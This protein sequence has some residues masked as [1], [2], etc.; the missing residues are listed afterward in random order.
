[1]SAPAAAR[2]ECAGRA[3]AAQAAPGVAPRAN[4]RGDAATPRRTTRCES[5]PC[6][7]SIDVPPGTYAFDLAAGDSGAELLQTLNLTFAQG[8]RSESATNRNWEGLP[9]FGEGLP[10]LLGGLRRPKRDTVSGALVLEFRWRIQPIHVASIGRATDD[11]AAGA[12]DD[13]S[14]NEARPGLHLGRS[15]NKGVAS[16]HWLLHLPGAQGSA[17]RNPCF[18]H[19]RSCGKL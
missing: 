8:A 3:R 18:V 12:G 5:L 16:P 9:S 11:V 17:A 14:S 19:F 13:R 7:P 1:M 6:S 2:T 15:A 4:R 10:R